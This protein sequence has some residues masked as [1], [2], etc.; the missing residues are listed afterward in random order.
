MP[1]SLRSVAGI[2]SCDDVSVL[3][4][5]TCLATGCPSFSHLIVGIGQAC[6]RWTTQVF[7]LTKCIDK[8]ESLAL[9]YY[10]REPES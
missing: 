10:C 6:Q 1:V 2:I 5:L 9:L 3:S 4:T 8:R 7:I